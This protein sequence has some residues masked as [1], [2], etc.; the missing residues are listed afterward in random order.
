MKI[1]KKFHAA[2]LF[3][4]LLSLVSLFAQTEPKPDPEGTILIEN[5]NPA[6]TNNFNGKPDKL[7]SL[8]VSGGTVL[9]LGVNQ[10]AGDGSR[11]ITVTP[12]FPKAGL[13]QVVLRWATPKAGMFGHNVPITKAAKRSSRS[14][15]AVAMP[16]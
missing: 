12:T 2:L 14:T 15:S 1:Y 4:S 7:G 9:K 16:G 8:E 10:K 13:Y 5:D 11:S 3:A 6:V